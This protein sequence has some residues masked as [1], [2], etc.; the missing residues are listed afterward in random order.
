MPVLETPR[1]VVLANPEVVPSHHKSL[2]REFN[3]KEIRHV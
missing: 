3:A 1:F 2:R